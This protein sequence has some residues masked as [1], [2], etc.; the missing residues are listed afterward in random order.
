MTIVH[1][2]EK[3]ERWQERIERIALQLDDPETSDLLQELVHE[4]W[5]LNALVTTVQAQR[6]FDRFQAFSGIRDDCCPAC[7][8]R[9]RV[10]ETDP[11]RLRLISDSRV[12]AS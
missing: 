3:L 7:G 11:S 8:G 4:L 2:E 9:V 12:R 5:H 10:D 6:M 1:T